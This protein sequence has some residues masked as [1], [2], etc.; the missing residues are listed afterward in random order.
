MGTIGYKSDREDSK[1]DYLLLNGVALNDYL[2]T[3]IAEIAA[4]FRAL[5][6]LKLV[7]TD[8]LRT[9]AQQA[10]LLHSRLSRGARLDIYRNQKLAG[11]LAE[12]FAASRSSESETIAALTAVI[13]A[14][15]AKGEF[16]S[17][18]L[19]GRAVDVRSV[20]LTSR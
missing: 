18:H 11:E 5:T 19:T 4:R 14:Q 10:K 20:G 17:K 7:V 16:I 1:S 2:E 9:P 13:E 3:R 6:E 8:G 15:V 12:V